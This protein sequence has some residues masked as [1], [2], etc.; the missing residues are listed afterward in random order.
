MASVIEIIF[1]GVDQVSKITKGIDGSLGNLGK[2]VTAVG[3][4]MTAGLTL[5]IV[6]FG[7]SAVESAMAAESELAELNQILKASGGIAGVSAEQVT[8]FGSAMQKVT[9]FSDEEIVSGQSM[10]L[11]FTKLGKD[12]FPQA[13]KTMLDLAQFMGTDARSAALILGKALND[14]VEGVGALSRA[15]LK[16][17]DEETNMIKKMVEMGDVAGAQNMILQALRVQGIDGLAEA[18]GKTSG[19][20]MAQFTNQ[21]DDLKE[22]VG[23]ALIPHLVTLTGFLSKIVEGFMNLSPWMQKAIIGF[24]AFVA[25]VGPLLL[26]VGSIISAIATLGPVLATIGGVITGSL[27][28][29]I[30]AVVTALAP[31]LVPILAII[32]VIALLWLAWKNNFLGIRDITA[33]VVS[34]ISNYWNNVFLPA[35]KQVWSFIQENLVPIFRAV[36]DVIGAVVGLAFRVWMGYIQNV[37]IPIL[38]SLWQFIDAN[39]MPII[40]ALAEFI[41]QRLAPAFDGVGNAIRGAVDWLTR[42]AERINNLE[43]PSWLTPGSPTPLELGLVGIKNALA[44]VAAVN[45]FMGNGAAFSAGAVGLSAGGIGGPVTVI[46]NYNP[47]LSTANQADI[48][49]LMPLIREGALRVLKDAGK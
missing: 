9:K 28:P 5:P 7:K 4:V 1:K 10:L 8:E 32:A 22:V 19:G 20:K 39:I 21:L 17:T 45:P 6:A 46:V 49:R 43:L 3:G 47:T 23:A 35:L 36:G 37:T 18:F 14:P 48:E 41:S 42:L 26:I 16:F 34:A 38:K 25:V 12:V 33:S 13:S 27:I 15:G 40:R 2:S 30:G 31:V 11:T 29:A 44:D 24:L